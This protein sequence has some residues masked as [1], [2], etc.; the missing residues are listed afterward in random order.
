M[1]NLEG[2]CA[3]SNDTIRYSIESKSPSHVAEEPT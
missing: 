3:T 1:S 2:N